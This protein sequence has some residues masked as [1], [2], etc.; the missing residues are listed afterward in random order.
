MTKDSEKR[1]VRRCLEGRFLVAC[2]WLNFVRCWNFDAAPTDIR[3]DAI[4]CEL[5]EGRVNELQA[6]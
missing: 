1:G 5:F 3:S 4:A 2:W 6:D